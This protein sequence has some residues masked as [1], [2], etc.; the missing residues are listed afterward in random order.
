MKLDCMDLFNTIHPGFF[1]KE[2]F[3]SLPVDAVYEE[4]ILDLSE[5]MPEA[6]L[7]S[8]PEH[9]TFGIYEGDLA[10]LHAAVRSVEEDWTA[11]YT[12]D[13]EI[14]CAYD[15]ERII[16]FCLL[17][18]FGTYKGLRIGAPGCVGTIPE[19]RRQGVGLRLVQQAT[20]IFKERGYD[21]SYIHF[22]G[23]GHWY[24]RLGYRTIL[25][26]NAQGMIK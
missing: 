16:S 21:L 9:V 19:Y 15:G 14:Y 2:H 3:R 17:D 25:K 7:V 1:E 5:C 6:L 24:A 18:D 20:A 4:Q 10:P 26:W 12:A 11:Y 8:C 22:T 13:Q 23:V